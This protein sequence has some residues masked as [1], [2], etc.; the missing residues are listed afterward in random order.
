MTVSG[1]YRFPTAECNE[2]ERET[3]KQNET[4]A[5]EQVNHTYIY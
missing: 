4:N 5:R 1:R 2:K 3:M